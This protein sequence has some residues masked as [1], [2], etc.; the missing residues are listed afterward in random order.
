MHAHPGAGDSVE[1]QSGN[2]SVRRRQVVRPTS[3]AA[4][5]PAL[6]SSQACLQGRR[7]RHMTL[8]LQTKQTQRCN[9]EVLTRH[10]GRDNMPHY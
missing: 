7:N 6:P 5:N 1:Q 4:R 9:E 10:T 3:G 2:A 8:Q